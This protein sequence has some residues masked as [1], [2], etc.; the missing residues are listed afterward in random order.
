MHEMSPQYFLDP[1]T[2]RSVTNRRGAQLLLFCL[3]RTAM[4]NVG[5]NC[6]DTVG[7]MP[8][9]LLRGEIVNFFG[10]RNT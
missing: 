9:V 7:T 6:D 4:I 3:G 8:I 5:L 2:S 1:R 10:A